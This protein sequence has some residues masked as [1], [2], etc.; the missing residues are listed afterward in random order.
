MLLLS[1]SRN[2][3]QFEKPERQGASVYIKRTFILE[4]G[5]T[6]FFTAT[7]I[8]LVI[9]H[10]QVTTLLFLNAEAATGGVL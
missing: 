7:K 9:R 5:T 10:P 6:M 3:W 2:A 8:L 4:K 1:L